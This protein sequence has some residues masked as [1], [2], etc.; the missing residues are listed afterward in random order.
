VADIIQFVP[1]R[2]LSARRNLREFITL[3]KEHLDTWS[4]L[5]GFAWEGMRWPTTYSAVRFQNHENRSLH[6]SVTPELHQLMHPAFI[7]V[8]KAYLRYQHTVNPH[9]NISRQMQ[10]LRALEFALRQDMGIPDITKV[11]QR[12]FDQAV[13]ALAGAKAAAAIVVELL[14]ILQHLGDFFI[15]TPTSNYWTHPYTGKNS[16]DSVNGGGATQF[17]KDGKVANQD[18]L[19]AI[20]DVF[21]RGYTEPL[22]DVDVMVNGITALLLSA[23]TRLGETLRFR[24]DFLG[25]DTDKNGKVQY[26]LKYWVPK[27]RE[28]ARKPVPEVM[29]ETAIEAIRRLTKITEEARRLARYMEGKPTKFYRHEN[30]PNVSDDQILTRDQV[31]EALGFASGKSCEDYVKRWTGRRVL[32]GFSLS[33]LWEIAL[34]DHH[35]SNPHFPYQEPPSGSKHPLLKMSESLMCARRFQFAVDHTTSPILL[36]PFNKDYFTKRLDAVEKPNRKNTRPMCFFTRHGFESIKLKSHGIRHLL[37]R[38]AKQSGISIEVITA[39]S[40]RSTF[41][42]TL[43]YLD[44]DEGQAAAAVSSLM[45]IANEQSP[46]DPITNEEADIYSLG[47]IHR[48][49]YGLCRRSWRA[50][51]CNKFGDCLNCSELLICK[52]DKVASSIIAADRD[53]LLNTYNAATQAIQRGEKSATR[54]LRVAEPQIQ[55]LN[56]LITILNDPTIADGSPV[57]IAGTDFSHEQVIIDDKAK[58][59]GVK[60][61]DRSLL[62]IE[63][64]DD[65]L[66][67]LDE[68]RRPRDA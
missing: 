31:A 7:D 23:P 67:C 4:T 46:K 62:A 63:Y 16:Y 29:A 47:P 54:W 1:R 68:L 65:L 48:S 15:V 5:D 38:I 44:N 58:A 33:S 42:Q 24:V 41:R 39:W 2:D 51:P 10:G 37:N 19:L 18:A 6:P 17:V 21:G 12:H 26:Y 27:T 25:S 43:T 64:G 61:L 45:G 56:Q 49:R 57:E 36:A 60:L 40:N 52:G 3:S 34:K 35:Q 14:R 9:R 59:A 28:F 50:G 8:A 11:S 53:N 32:T 55:R 13:T 20:G 22:D 30:C 66:A